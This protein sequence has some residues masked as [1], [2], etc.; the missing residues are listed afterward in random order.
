MGDNL[1]REKNVG[2]VVKKVMDFNNVKNVFKLALQIT[3]LN[4]IVIIKVIVQNL[5]LIGVVSV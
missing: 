2:L 3:I 4:K 1:C 5:V